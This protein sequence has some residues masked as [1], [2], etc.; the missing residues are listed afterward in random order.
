[1][2][3][4]LTQRRYMGSYNRY[5]VKY[6]QDKLIVFAM[7]DEF[8]SDF[9]KGVLEYITTFL[10]TLEEKEE[11]WHVG[12]DILEKYFENV[13]AGKYNLTDW[14]YLWNSNGDFGKVFIEIMQ[15]YSVKY[16]FTDNED[17]YPPG[18]QKPLSW[19]E[20]LEWNR[21]LS[22]WENDSRQINEEISRYTLMKQEELKAFIE[23][24][25]DMEGMYQAYLARLEE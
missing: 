17:S 12:R 15:D 16:C 5:Y 6:N 22:E 3:V 25:F 4:H 24:P 14:K 19:E 7:K 13:H 1:M 8:G 9:V 21:P 18:N 11:L 20:Y 23:Y 10:D 2:S